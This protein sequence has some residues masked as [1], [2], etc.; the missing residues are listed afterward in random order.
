MDQHTSTC[1]TCEVEKPISEFGKDKWSKTGRNRECKPCN[2]E[3]SRRYYEKAGRKKRGHSTARRHTPRPCLTCEKTFKPRNAGQIYCSMTCSGIAHRIDKDKVQDPGRIRNQPREAVQLTIKPCSTCGDM[4]APHREDHVNCS[5]ECTDKARR[6]KE[7]HKNNKRRAWIQ[8]TQLE[9]IDPHD[10]YERDG[11]TCWI[12]SEPIN[13]EA[14]YPHPESVSLDHVRPL[15]W[16]GTHTRDNL[17]ASHLTCNQARGARGEMDAEA[18]AFRAQAIKSLKDAFGLYGEWT[19]CPSREDLLVGNDGRVYNLATGRF[20]YKSTVIDGETVWR[21]DTV[22]ETLKEQKPGPEHAAR[23]INGDV[24]DFT[25]ENLAWEIPESK[26]KKKN[27]PSE[28]KRGHM[29]D[30]ANA[31]TA[32]QCRCCGRAE[33]RNKSR[34]KTMTEGQIQSLADTY[35]REMLEAEKK[36]W[37]P[38]P[39]AEGYSATRCGLV[40]KDKTGRIV[41]GT[42]KKHRHMFGAN[43]KSIRFDR[44]VMAAHGIKP[45]SPDSYPIHLD[46]DA[47]NHSL[48]NLAWSWPGSEWEVSRAAAQVAAS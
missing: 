32:N 17:A 12:C 1:P 26:D 41:K 9:P 22:L 34:G 18:I 36:K 39:D 13:R 47:T 25:P 2:S 46:G 30:G 20:L 42:L 15:S 43:G 45:P 10:I 16:G 19:P 29:V 44:A 8:F 14:R 7:S 33:G 21:A 37:S 31:D 23:H 48:E 24:T 35:Y 27:E 38:I 3:R 40:R 28:C 11:W 4:F 5:P 6:I